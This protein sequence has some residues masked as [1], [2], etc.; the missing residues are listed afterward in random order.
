MLLPWGGPWLLLRPDLMVLLLVYWTIREPML[1]GGWVAFFLGILADSADSSTLGIHALGYSMSYYLAA[2]F[3]PR[4]L[5]FYT[6]NQALHV[7]PFI[8]VSQLTT[9]LVSLI[10][11]LPLPDWLWWLQSP[12]TALFWLTLPALL[13]R[14]KSPP[15]TPKV[16]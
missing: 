10:L 9:T 11:K 2:H 4:I 3:R 13:E 1:M 6:A 15:D 5:S 7:L 12:F 8:F 16:S 14:Q